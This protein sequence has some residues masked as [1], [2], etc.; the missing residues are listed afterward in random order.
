MLDKEEGHTIYF[1]QGGKQGEE[2]RKETIDE[3]VEQRKGGTD[4]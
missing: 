3:I 4:L 1:R 2:E